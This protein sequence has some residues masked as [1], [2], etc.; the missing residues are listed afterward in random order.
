MLG[1][2]KCLPNNLWHIFISHAYWYSDIKMQKI[3]SRGF[4]S[5]RICR[6]TL[7]AVLMAIS[8]QS[9][10]NGPMQ[11]RKCFLITKRLSSDTP[12][13]QQIRKMPKFARLGSIAKNICWK[14][15]C[16]SDFDFIGILTNQ[17]NR[18][19]VKNPDVRR[20]DC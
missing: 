3:Y 4:F 20:K 13:H 5:L 9:E 16:K 12:K 14:I 6:Q 1:R 19:M 7:W 17:I 11:S 10:K 18:F 8:N 15:W 2:E